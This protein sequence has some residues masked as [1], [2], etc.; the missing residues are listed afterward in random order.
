M[1]VNPKSSPHAL[2]LGKDTKPIRLAMSF[3][4]KA[5]SSKRL[6]CDNKF[7]HAIAESRRQGVVTTCKQ[8]CRLSEEVISA[9]TVHKPPALAKGTGYSYTMLW[10]LFLLIASGVQQ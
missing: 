10:S 9:L 6:D 5:I 7:M 2:V 1:L 4:E 3:L 8:W